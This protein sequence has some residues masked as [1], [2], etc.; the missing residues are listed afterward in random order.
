MKVYIKASVQHISDMAEEELLDIAANPN[1]HPDILREISN[2]SNDG[3]II[4][5]EFLV[6]H[7]A[8]NPNTPPDVLKRFATEPPFIHF[9]S[10][11]RRVASNP[12]T[13]P[14]VLTNLVD[15][16]AYVS[17]LVAE[18]PNTPLDTLKQLAQPDKF[19]DSRYG[20]VCNK[21]LSE[22]LINI[23]I[24]DPDAD[25]RS[26]LA[27]KE[28]LPKSAIEN[29]LYRLVD[30]PSHLVRYSVA[31]N[32]YCPAELLHRLVD[33]TDDLVRASVAKNLNTATEDL[34]KLSGDPKHYV[35]SVAEQQL[36]QRGV[37]R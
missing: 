17:S 34:L 16:S 18:N 21:N 28:D 7:L 29:I 22:E 3:N 14:E 24:E 19:V 11:V 9:E 35:C 8:Q 13:P 12:S 10:I 32:S 27:D 30:D 1:A 5:T 2:I 4:D 31:L 6:R 20:V 25:I 33:D 15:Y 23:L 36:R 37:K 26:E